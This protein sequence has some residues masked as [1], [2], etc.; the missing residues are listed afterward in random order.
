[1]ND[2]KM[3]ST[4]YRDWFTPVWVVPIA[5]LILVIFYAFMR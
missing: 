4:N 2:N 1:M 3:P 5:L